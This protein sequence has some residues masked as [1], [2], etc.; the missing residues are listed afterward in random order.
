MT[1]DE[2]YRQSLN[3]LLRAAVV[4]AEILED[5][6]LNRTEENR[7][8]YSTKLIEDTIKRQKKINKNGLH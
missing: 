6:K 3:D 8:A 7:I 2:L 1:K 4:L 5:K